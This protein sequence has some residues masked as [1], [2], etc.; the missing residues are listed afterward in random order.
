M[1]IFLLATCIFLALFVF[2]VFRIWSPKS[3]ST[4][5]LEPASSAEW[6]AL[7]GKRDE[8]E[9]DP[10]LSES[11]KETLRAEWA[12]TA[13]RILAVNEAQAGK[14][15]KGNTASS[16]AVSP[17]MPRR[18]LPYLSG[19]VVLLT[20]T[21]YMCVGSLAPLALEMPNAA[22]GNPMAV[23][24]EPPPMDGAKHP[25]DDETLEERAARLEEKLKQNPDDID[26]WV[27]LARTKGVQRDFKGEAEAL[28]Q[29]LRLSPGHPDLMADLADT[30]AM[31]NNKTMA[32]E[33]AALVEQVLKADPNHRK[34]LALAATAA[35]QNHDNKTAAVF[36][37]R[38]RATFPPD[39]PDLARI[40][41]ILAEIGAMPAPT[42]KAAPAENTAGKRD[43]GGA[44]A[45]ASISGEVALDK[46]LLAYIS[47]QSVP[48]SA[49][50]YVFAKMESGPPMP[51][52]VM[53]TSPDAL[54]AG[55]KIPFTL[56]DS[57]A[58]SPAF[59]ISSTQQVNLEA[60]LSMSGN[61][62][63]QPGDLSVM[64]P[65]VKVGSQ[66]LQLVIQSTVK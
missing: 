6:E 49:V 33:P 48:A 41:E 20:L 17:D 64:I 9:R 47:K 2:L 1:T 27:L 37:Q 43:S 11:T 40:D 53:R 24:A 8:I 34:G 19:G 5:R 23:T 61:A 51:L 16:N 66:G 10:L 55:H 39:A 32:G 29:A 60:R 42:A 13:D 56:D 35:M 59:K 15:G 52:A 46:S 28:Q 3:S 65:G 7:L 36:W 22:S 38:L 26:G 50:L 63:K 45:G 21:T 58:M 12:V 62:I 25:G 14:S 30:K 57:L 18:W 44:V 4:N 31:L 54:L